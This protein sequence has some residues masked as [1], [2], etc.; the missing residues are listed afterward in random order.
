MNIL[1]IVTYILASLASL[2][3]LVLVAMGFLLLGSIAERFQ[4]ITAPVPAFPQGYSA[5][6][7]AP[8]DPATALSAAD[9]DALAAENVALPNAELNP[10]MRDAGCGE[11]LD[12]RESAAA[13]DEEYVDPLEGADEGYGPTSGEEQF[14]YGCE[15]GYITEGC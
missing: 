11:W 15:Q 12:A 10:F 8:P 5:A 13:E 2:A 4:G 1:R 7:D 14:R 6:P 3:F 9:C